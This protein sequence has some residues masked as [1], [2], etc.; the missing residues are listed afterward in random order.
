MPNYLCKESSTRVKVLILPAKNS[1]SFAKNLISMTTYSYFCKRIQPHGLKVLSSLPRIHPQAKDSILAV[2]I[3]ILRIHP[4]WLQISSSTLTHSSKEFSLVASVFIQSI[5]AQSKI[6]SSQPTYQ[7]VHLT[8]SSS[9][10]TKDLIL[11][12]QTY[13]SEEAILFTANIF[14]KKSPSLPTCSSKKS[15]SSLGMY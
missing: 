8:N 13:S 12:P 9:S 7:H 4:H 14:M 11:S 1:S 3:F 15:S 10:P 6:S 5:Y 2:N